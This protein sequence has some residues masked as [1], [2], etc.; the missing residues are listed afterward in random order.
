MWLRILARD[1]CSDLVPPYCKPMDTLSPHATEVLTRHLL[2]I[3]R[4]T[5]SDMISSTRYTLHQPRSITWVRLI[6]GLWLLVAASDATTSTLSMW[7]VQ[8]TLSCPP[9]SAAPAAVIYLDG[10]VNRGEVHV[11]EE[12]VLIALEMRSLR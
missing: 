2:R 10:R 9:G 11:S 5:A 4:A 1:V 3:Q 7:S 6:H 8:T 12:Q